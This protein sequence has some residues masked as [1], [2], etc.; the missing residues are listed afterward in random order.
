MLPPWTVTCQVP[1]S[2]GF[3][4]QEYWLPFPSP[5]DLPNPRNKPGCP[6]SEVDSLLTSY[7]L[8]FYC[9]FTRLSHN[10]SFFCSRIPS[11]VPCSLRHQSS[12][13]PLVYERSVGPLF[14][15][16]LIVLRRTGQVFCRMSLSMG[17]LIV[18]PCLDRD[19]GF[20]K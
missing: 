20:W 5:G 18:Y 19:D 15:M 6:A 11:T 12:S 9:D 16:I 13:Y 2:T 1:L 4:R 3:S 10:S 14:L 7:T 17:L 8:N